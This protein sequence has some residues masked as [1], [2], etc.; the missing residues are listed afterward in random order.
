MGF[1]G[2][3]ASITCIMGLLVYRYLKE[4]LARIFEL[5]RKN[6]LIVIDTGTISVILAA[7]R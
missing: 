4:G 3:V 1:A 2:A 7:L 5:P 6:E